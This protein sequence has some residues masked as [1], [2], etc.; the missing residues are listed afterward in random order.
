MTE[1]EV[2]P[3]PFSGLDTFPA[4]GAVV[5]CLGIILEDIVLVAVGALI[6]AGGVTLIL[7]VGAA[8]VKGAKSLF[9]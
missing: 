2:E 9:N 3:P 8:V 5:V 6:G 7:T 1:S 4:L